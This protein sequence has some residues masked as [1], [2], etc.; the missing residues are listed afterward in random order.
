MRRDVDCDAEQIEVLIKFFS[1]HRFLLRWI[2]FTENGDARWTSQR[3][4][5]LPKGVGGTA[6]LLQGCDETA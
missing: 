2:G 6:T 3:G 5:S 1:V 4:C